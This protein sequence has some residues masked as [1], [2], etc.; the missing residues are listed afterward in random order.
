M[1]IIPPTHTNH[2]PHQSIYPDMRTGIE[3]DLTP[4]KSIQ[5]HTDPPS[6]TGH[7]SSHAMKPT[8]HTK[9]YPVTQGDQARWTLIRHPANGT[10]PPGQWNLSTTP[11]DQSIYPATH[12]DHSSTHTME[13]STGLTHTR[14]P[15]KGT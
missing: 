4:D 9:C 6:H 15:M 5:P 10:Y 13:P 2:P 11:T 1:L 3:V 14:A 8:Q 7:L 12:R